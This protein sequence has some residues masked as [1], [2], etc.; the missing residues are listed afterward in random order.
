VPHHLHLHPF[1]DQGSWVSEFSQYDAGCLHIFKSTNCGDIHRIKWADLNIPA[2]LSTL[3]AAGV[4][5]V[6]YDNQGSI[7]AS[8][9]L[10]RELD[11]GIF[12][13]DAEH[14]VAQLREEVTSSRLRENAWQQREQF[15]FDAHADHL[16]RFFHEVIESKR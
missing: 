3:V 12:Y 6:Q 10:L 2:R 5:P 14:L 15:T 16:I 9:S 4:P 8:Q 11:I 7:V 13:T 1:V